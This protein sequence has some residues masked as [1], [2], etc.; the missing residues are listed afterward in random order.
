MH[1]SRQS[2][3]TARRLRSASITVELLLN[4][5]I[6]LILLIALVGFGRVLGDAQQVSLASRVGAAVASQS[7]GLPSANQLPDE[8]RDAVQRSLNAAGLQACQVIL[9]HNAG[10]HPFTCAAGTHS[11][12]SPST[13]LPTDGVYVRITVLARDPGLAASLLHWIG[14]DSTTLG[15]RQSSTFRYALEIQNPSQNSPDPARPPQP[16][17]PPKVAQENRP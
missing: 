1:A 14:L 3:R 11:G 6:W 4:L 12:T 13:P 16:A 10:G 17:K 15:L 8:V 2:P 5:P 7:S 9:E